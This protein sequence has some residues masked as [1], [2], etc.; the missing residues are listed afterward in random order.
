MQSLAVSCECRK[1]EKLKNEWKYS[2]INVEQVNLLS[3]VLKFGI[4][5]HKG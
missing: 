3:L 2:G 1:I 5:L 4:R